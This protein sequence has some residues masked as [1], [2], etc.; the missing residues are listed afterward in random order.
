MEKAWPY[1]VKGAGGGRWPWEGQNRVF[2][3]FWQRGVSATKCFL[4]D[5]K[6]LFLAEVIRFW[7]LENMGNY[8]TSANFIKHDFPKMDFLE[9]K[10]YILLQILK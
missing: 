8:S 9:F 4:P 5:Q 6:I 3:C 7:N 10:M 2:C 1:I